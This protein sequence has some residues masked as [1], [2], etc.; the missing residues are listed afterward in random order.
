MICHKTQ[1]IFIH[2]PGCAGSSIEKAIVGKDW[3]DVNPQTKHI[4]ASTAKRIYA[5]HWD[6]Y[7]KFSIVRHPFDRMKSLAR[8]PEFYGVDIKDGLISVDEYLNRFSKGEVDHRCVGWRNKPIIP[9]GVYV[10]YINEPIDY[11]MR[12]ETIDDH[13]GYIKYRLGVGDLPN[14]RPCGPKYW[15][16]PAP[17]AKYSEDT[18]KKVKA[19]YKKDFN[20][21]YRYEDRGQ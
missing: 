21:W 2:I 4:S 14:V 19:I 18:K 11:I 12:F 16:K 3:F 5:D 20:K 1:S 17:V 6:S 15:G 8:F 13:W 9:N 10:N 7:F